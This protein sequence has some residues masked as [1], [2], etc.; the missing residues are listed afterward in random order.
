MTR[1]ERLHRCYFYQELDRPAVNSRMNIPAN[2]PT[3]DR[4]RQYLAQHTEIRKHWPADL[5]QT[6]YPM[7]TDTEPFTEDF[8]REVTRL[9][10]PAGELTS[11]FLVSLKGQPGLQETYLLKNTEDIEKYLSL[12]LPEVGGDVSAYFTENEKIGDAGIVET[13]LGFNP[14]GFVVEL[15]GTENFALMSLTNRDWLHT[16]CARQLQIVMNRLKFFISQKIGPYFSML[17]EEYIVPPIHSPAD[18]RDFNMRYDQPIIDLIHEAGGRIQ[19]HSHGLMQRVLSLFVEMG[20]DV[21]HPFE[22]APQGD[23]SATEAKSV[24]RGRMCLEGN[25]QI[26]RM[27]EANPEAIREE[28]ENLIRD[29]FDDRCGLIVSP[30]ASPYIRGLGE[31][32]FPQYQALIDTVRNW[33]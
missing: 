27:Y 26:H 14:A 19:I 18:F 9:C 24:A 11:S 22:S 15:L 20:T 16:L 10:T 32:C 23:I 3:Y 33:R 25:I 31:I 13:S 6:A 12:P 17:G 21:L 28:T 2:D 30:T 8:A 5:V 4:L 7:K 1:R 29:A